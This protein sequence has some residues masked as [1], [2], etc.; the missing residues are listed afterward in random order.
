MGRKEGRREGLEQ[1]A[2]RVLL[3]LL[4]QRFGQLP[5]SVRRRVAEI[6]SVERLTRLAERV[7]TA[8]SLED[9]GLTPRSDSSNG[10]PQAE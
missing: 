4:G 3:R 5:D 10:L 9:V 2:R 1:G 8:S 7:L 6:D